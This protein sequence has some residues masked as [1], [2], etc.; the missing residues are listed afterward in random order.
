MTVDP[1]VIPP[2]FLV[3]VVL[4]ASDAPHPAATVHVLH[5]DSLGHADALSWAVAHP[6]LLKLLAFGELGGDATPLAHHCRGVMSRPDPKLGHQGWRSSAWSLYFAIKNPDYRDPTWD[7][8][9]GGVSREEFD[10]HLRAA[11]DGTAD[12]G[13]TC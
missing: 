5:V 4:T 2:D 10:E 6:D 11:A 12:D 3:K 9:P 1:S 13:A 7:N 8:E